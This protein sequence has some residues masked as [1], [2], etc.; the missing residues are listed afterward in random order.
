MSNIIRS[1]YFQHLEDAKREKYIRCKEEGKRYL[2][3]HTFYEGHHYIAVLDAFVK[4]GE[5]FLPVL[6][7]FKITCD[8]CGNE[9][10][11]VNIDATTDW[12]CEFH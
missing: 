7:R 5:A 4:S 10:G 3:S 1:S 6:G 8:D 2:L 12:I 9:K 11:F